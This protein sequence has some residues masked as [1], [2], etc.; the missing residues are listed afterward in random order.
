MG[1]WTKM[2]DAYWKYVPYDWRPRQL[3]YQ[4]KCWAWCRHTT[5]KPRWLPHTWIDRDIQLAHCMFEV[6]GRFI[7]GELTE[8]DFD[9]N[10]FGDTEEHRAMA[11]E[12]IAHHVELRDLWRWWT[13]VYLKFDAYDKHMGSI[14]HPKPTETPKLATSVFQMLGYTF[15]SPEAEEVFNAASKR[16]RE[17]EAAMEAELKSRLKRLV[18]LKDRMWV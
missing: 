9:R 4:F 2:R 12:Q 3:W 18:D 13:D 5:V 15:S 8:D 11:D 14:E 6:L 1:V 16:V 17:D 10:S 7:E